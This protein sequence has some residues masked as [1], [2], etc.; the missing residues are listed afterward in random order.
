MLPPAA[1]EVAVAVLDSEPLWRLARA[2][3]GSQRAESVRAL[4]R[5]AERGGHDVVV[6]SAVLVEVY[7][8]G[9]D[10]AA[11]DRMIAGARIGVVTTGR[12][13]ARV[14]ARLLTRDGLDSCHVVDALVVAAAVR[15]GG[16]VVLTGDPDDLRSLA[17][18]HSNV[19][20]S[21]L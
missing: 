18:D 19:R 2:R 7:R 1:T 11:V 3:T 16:G 9:A 14:A 5:S 13:M 20:V 4:L 8:G 17:R 10:D 21:P 6:P 12:A 15:L